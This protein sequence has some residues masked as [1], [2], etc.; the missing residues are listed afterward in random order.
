MAASKTELWAQVAV[1]AKVFDELYKFGNENTP[2]F[3]AMKTAVIEALEGDH[4]AVTARV[5]NELQNALSADFQ[6][7]REVL[8]ALFKELA[9]NGYGIN[10][11]GKNIGQI[12]TDIS[13]AMAGSETIASRDL[14]FGSVSAG[15]S[16]VSTGLFWRTTLDRHNQ[17]IES[18][19]VGAVKAEVISDKNSG[20]S[21]GEEQY[22]IYGSGRIKVDEIDPGATTNLSSVF[23]LISQGSSRNLLT[24][25]DFSA[26]EN[27]LTKNQQTGW[28]LS[29]Y[30][31][32]SKDNTIKHRW[33]GGNEGIVNPVGHSLKMTANAW[34]AQYFTRESLGRKVDLSKPFFMIVLYYRDGADGELEIRLG[35]STNSVADLTAVD[36]ES[37][38]AVAIGPG[39][40]DGWF[41][42]FN[43][44]WPDTAA[45][46][47]QALGVRV[48]VEWKSRTTGDL[49]IGGVILAQPNLFNGTYHLIT[50]GSN[51]QSTSGEARK[52][53]IWTYTDS[54]TT[55]GVAQGRIQDII[56]KFFPGYY[57]PHTTGTEDYEDA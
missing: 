56:R 49:Y 54:Y 5:M 9:S 20:A 30:T 6:K 46:L 55:G 11:T 57:L 52:G 45:S 33:K 16:N 23:N 31:N 7:G 24:N 47:N 36:D 42:N 40:D 8:A 48:R 19:H 12:L 32:F 3:V 10:T 17:K 4:A 34:F 50:A 25:G 22:R 28:T 18:V 51:T 39:S 29:D 35:A 21:P 53:D 15:G 14:T 44:D 38:L 27:T 13:N 1:A 43:E 41:D 2:N 37:W 26:I